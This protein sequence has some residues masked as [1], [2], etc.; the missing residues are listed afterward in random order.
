MAGDL[1]A[2]A[3]RDEMKEPG[4]GGW[5]PL[6]RAL[7][8]SAL[9][10]AHPCSGYGTARDPTSPMTPPSLRQAPREGKGQSTRPFAKLPH[11]IAADPRLLPIDVRLLLAIV[12]YAMD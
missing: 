10:S 8:D 5:R 2:G 12:Y 7:T 1:P 4:E 9:A 11:D 6:R 3:L